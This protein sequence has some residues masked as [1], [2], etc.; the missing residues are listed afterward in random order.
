MER[1]QRKSLHY[2]EAAREPDEDAAADVAYLA[3]FGPRAIA[4]VARVVVPFASEARSPGG[5]ATEAVDVGA[6]SGA[7]ALVLL[8]LGV[9][10]VHLVER[11]TRALDLAAK[12]LDPFTIEGA[13]PGASVVR[14][15][16]DA[17]TRPRPI[18]GAQWLLSSFAF[19][20]LARARTEDDDV[21]ATFKQ[22]EGWAPN[23]ERAFLVDAGDRPRAR[24]IQA[25]RDALVV[26]GRGVLAPCPHTDRCPALVRERDWCHTRVEKRLPEP[27]ARFAIGVGRDDAEMS[28]SYV[29]VGWAGEQPLSTGV[30]VIGEAR[31][32]KGR[33][34]LPVCGARG[35][36]FLQATKKHREA[37]DTLITLARGV[38]LDAVCATDPRADTAHV[39]DAAVL[40]AVAPS[41][42][43]PP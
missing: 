3:H 42:D 33:A 32:E 2:T 37:H 36:R 40:Q 17:R 4:A 14:V 35:L 43:G 1:A 30:R 8:L 39:D 19:G 24:A 11:S 26:E 13:A 21:R 12:L 38:V 16:H 28:L 22:I 20:E 29:V 31:V 25:L 18:A 10:T 23:A 41:N 34:R 27:F 7:S 6:G 15:V 9:K 5:V